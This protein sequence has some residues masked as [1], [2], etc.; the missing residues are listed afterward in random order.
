MM[1]NRFIQN[2]TEE[3]IKE[4]G[5]LFCLQDAVI[6]LDTIEVEHIMAGS[7]NTVI[8]YGKATGANRCA[9]AIEDAVLHCCAVA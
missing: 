5:G 8:L 4:V 9:D 2:P 3:C 7:E 1:N 6:V